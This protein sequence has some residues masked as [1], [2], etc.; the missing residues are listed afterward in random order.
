MSG[1]SID[2][3]LKLWA[4]SLR[5]V[6]ARIRPLFRQARVA[7]SAGLFL[8]GLLGLRIKRPL[9]HQKIVIFR[10]HDDGIGRR[11]LSEPIAA[12]PAVAQHSEH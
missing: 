2:T 5:D 7:A 1:A 12:K 10:M 3:K 6:K 8:D 4:S 11:G 9:L